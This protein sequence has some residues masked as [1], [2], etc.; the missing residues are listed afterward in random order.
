M[1]CLLSGQAEPSGKAF[2][3]TEQLERELTSRCGASVA[4]EPLLPGFGEYALAAHGR[5]CGWP[6]RGD[7]GLLHVQLLMAQQLDASLP[8]FPS[9]PV[10]PEQGIL[11]LRMGDNSAIPL[12]PLTIPLGSTD[13]GIIVVVECNPRRIKTREQGTS[14]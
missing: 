14:L 4:C 12:P 9:W 3:N 7:D 1:F 10:M 8:L 2:W 6:I 13:T 5:R 11:P